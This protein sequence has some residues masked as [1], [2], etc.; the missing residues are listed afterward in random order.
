MHGINEKKECC[1]KPE[2]LDLNLM[3]QL[4]QLAAAADV[5]PM[6]FRVDCGTEDG[7]VV[8]CK[9]VMVVPTNID[10]AARQFMVSDRFVLGSDG[11][12]PGLDLWMLARHI[13][14]VLCDR[15]MGKF[16]ENSDF[17]SVI[18]S[19]RSEKSSIVLS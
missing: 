13:A 2:K 10:G 18:K 8:Y 6:V 4:L 11:Y 7:V 9:A 19:G 14:K 3:A 17:L 16:L 1:A 15:C 12:V 5:L